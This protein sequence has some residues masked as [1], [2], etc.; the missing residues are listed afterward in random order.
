M[1][2]TELLDTD[3]ALEQLLAELQGLK[4]TVLQLQEAGKTSTEAVKTAET[5]TNLSSTILQAS[6]RQTEAV[7][8]LAHRIEVLVED[9]LL[10]QLEKSQKVADASRWLIVLVLL[11]SA[12]NAALAY[13]SYQMLLGGR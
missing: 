2:S 3:K 6:T 9:R 8:S 5:V 4:S 1:A 11:L 12:A 10:P 13:M 7:T